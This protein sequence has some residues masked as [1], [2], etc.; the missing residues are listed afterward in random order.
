MRLPRHPD[1][2]VPRLAG[3]AYAD[4]GPVPGSQM[5]VD[6]GYS[7]RSPL[8]FV[9][10]G[11]IYPARGMGRAFFRAEYALEWAESKYGADRVS[12]IPESLDEGAVRWAVLVKNAR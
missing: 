5:A 1:Q 9:V 12:L 4:V 8:D 2:A 3:T 11:P 6:D 10:S 7:T